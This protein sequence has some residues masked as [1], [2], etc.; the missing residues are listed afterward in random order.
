[1]ELIA[2]RVL[3]PAQSSHLKEVFDWE[4]FGMSAVIA[5]LYSYLCLSQPSVLLQV[6]RLNSSDLTLQVSDTG[7]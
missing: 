1:M 7:S 4:P 2:L 5:V 6:A 3:K